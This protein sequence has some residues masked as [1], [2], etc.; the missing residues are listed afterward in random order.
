MV[1]HSDYTER[2]TRLRPSRGAEWAQKIGLHTHTTIIASPT[3]PM[4]KFMVPV[5]NRT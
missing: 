2:V 3:K 4:T 1:V 5:A